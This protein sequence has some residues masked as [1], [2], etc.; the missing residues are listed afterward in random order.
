MPYDDTSFGGSAQEFDKVPN[1][2]GFQNLVL[3]PQF[4]ACGPRPVGGL[5]PDGLAGTSPSLAKAA[6]QPTDAVGG[7]T[8]TA[9]FYEG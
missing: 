1:W 8:E 4:V 9:S 2:R 3:A 5:R 6:G 7:T